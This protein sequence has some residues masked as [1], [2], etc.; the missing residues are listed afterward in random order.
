MTGRD[1]PR[2]VCFSCSFGWGYQGNEEQLAAH[3]P[4]WLPVTCCGSLEAEQIL[5]AFR[6]GAD[7]VLILACPDGECHFQD[8]NQQCHKRVELLKKLLHQHGIDPS[9]L[10][11]EYGRDSSGGRI[12]DLVADMARKEA[13]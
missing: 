5:A 13:P 9:R 7:Q 4:F 3:L 6:D 11:M 8:G 2:I 10:R 12:V 1:Q